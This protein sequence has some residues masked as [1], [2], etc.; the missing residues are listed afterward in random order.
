VYYFSVIPSHVDWP[1][2][3]FTMTGAVLFCLLGA[4]IPAAKAA[5]TDPVKALQHE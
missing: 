1:S 3:I 2:S 4:I 5:D